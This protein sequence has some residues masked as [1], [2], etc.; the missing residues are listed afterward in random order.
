MHIKKCSKTKVGFY[1]FEVEVNNEE[2]EW[3]FNY[4]LNDLIKAGFMHVDLIEEAQ[5]EYDLFKDTGGEPS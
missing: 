3:L 2:A 1:K 4:A 5:F